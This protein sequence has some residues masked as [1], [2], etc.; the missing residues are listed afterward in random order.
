MKI[1]KYVPSKIKFY[2]NSMNP[3]TVNI[4]TYMK[5]IYVIFIKY[6]SVQN[7]R[8]YSLKLDLIKKLEQINPSNSKLCF[9]NF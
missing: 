5:N 2:K 9:T 6:I 8:S 3:Y 1:C 4:S 7:M